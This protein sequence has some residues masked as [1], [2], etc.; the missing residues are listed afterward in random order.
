M[1]WGDWFGLYVCGLW[2]AVE[3]EISLFFTFLLLVSWN[4]IVSF[5]VE[6]RN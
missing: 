3:N 1:A 6:K 5:T 4:R 2:E